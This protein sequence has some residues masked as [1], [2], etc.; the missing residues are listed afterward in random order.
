[1]SSDSDISFVDEPPVKIAPKKMK[2]TANKVGGESIL[3]GDN[4]NS[5]KI[6]KEDPMKVFTNIDK[7]T[8]RL[9]IEEIYQKKSQLEHIL[10]RP[11]TYIGSI[12]FTDKSLMW[13]YDEEEERIV[14]R[15]LSYVPGLYKIFDEILVNA[16]DNK[17][18]DPKM[19]LIKIAINKEKNEITIFNNGKGIP[20]VLHKVEQMY[21]PELIFGTLLTSSNYNDSDR[22]VTGGRN[23]YGAKLC[24]IF[25]K[26]FTVETSSKE[27]GKTFKQTWIN[28]MT[29]DKDAAISKATTEDF[30]RVI[31]SP[32]LEKFK[33]SVLD[34]DIIALMS[35]RAYDIAGSTRGVK[36]YLNNKLLPVSDIHHHFI[37]Y[38]KN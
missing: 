28:N 36:V 23:G 14:Q 30:T 27:Y 34:D 5:N 26:R 4:D 17:Q 19:N 33:M 24:N 2:K 29:K 7:S 9:S 32:D 18:R 16:A 15:E 38:G 25:S 13:A 11:D 22:K 20:V 37:F 21:V 6:N 10:L 8:K 3:N 12:E 31:F 1:M 35:R